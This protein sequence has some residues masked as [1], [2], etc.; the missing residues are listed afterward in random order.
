MN[1]I[2]TYCQKRIKQGSKNLYQA[3]VLGIEGTQKKKQMKVVN[4]LG[5]G[6]V[7]RVFID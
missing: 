3:C 1:K 4:L 7:K 6:K 5:G 2:V